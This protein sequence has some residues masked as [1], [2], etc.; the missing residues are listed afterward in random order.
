MLST[1]VR[2]QLKMT[3][4]RAASRKI[5]CRLVELFAGLK[6]RVFPRLAAPVDLALLV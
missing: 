3:T 2:T 5:A 6:V 1:V 4:A